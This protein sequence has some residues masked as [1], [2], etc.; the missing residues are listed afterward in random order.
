MLPMHQPAALRR[1]DVAPTDWNDWRWQLRHRLTRADELEA[2][3]RL[4]D[5]ERR[6]LQVAPGLFRVGVT[7]YYAEL[8][9]PE[10]ADC[11][12]RRQV[13]PVAAEA[14]VSDGEFR[15][16]LGE[17]GLM[18]APAIVHR[19]PDRVL[20][21][22]LDRCAVYCRHCN[23]RRLVGQ[24]D[25]VI[26]RQDLEAALDYVRR[27]PA[28]KDVLISGGD[29]LTLSTEKLEWLISSV[30]AIEH[31]DIV[32]LGTRVPVCLPMR[33]DD[34]LCA[35][36]KRYHPLY[37]NTHFNH[38]KEVTPEAR[39]ACER[40]ADAGIPVGNQTVLLRGVNS[41]PR[42]IENLNRLL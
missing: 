2:W 36:L 42:I 8:M 10:R 19:Y 23:R 1:R 14:H 26:S 12:V 30:R 32:R 24:D 4:S 28:I 22:A 7:P 34:E 33:I 41:E 3:V 17:D 25:G 38:P 37:I 31:V 15:D 21:L 27:T 5:D 6:G 16:P 39:A 20:L 13:I 29:P 11:P 40:L 9:D 18:P 35:M